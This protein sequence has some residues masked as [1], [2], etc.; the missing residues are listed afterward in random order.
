MS[1]AE[2]DLG[3]ESLWVFFSR[4]MF[5]ILVQFLLFFVNQALERCIWMLDGG[6]VFEV[7]QIFGSVSCFMGWLCG[8]YLVDPQVGGD[9]HF[10]LLG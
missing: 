9:L 1:L 5:G 3:E 2:G 6:R 10:D 4:V 7:V 8:T